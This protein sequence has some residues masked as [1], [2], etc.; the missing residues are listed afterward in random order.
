VCD[1]CPTGSF[2][3]LSFPTQGPQESF[4]LR[5]FLQARSS[6][7]PRPRPLPRLL[8]LAPVFPLV[9]A[10]ASSYYVLQCITDRAHRFR[11][12]LL[13]RLSMANGGHRGGWSIVLFMMPMTHGEQLQVVLP[14]SHGDF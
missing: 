12:T 13:H 6:P 10:L 14:V 5:A 11:F 2:V 8:A 4:L 9:L 3:W 7:R 1:Q